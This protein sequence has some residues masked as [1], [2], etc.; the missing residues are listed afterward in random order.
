MNSMVSSLAKTWNGKDFDFSKANG[1][2]SGLNGLEQTVKNNAKVMKSSTGI[3]DDFFNYFKDKKI[4]VS[5]ELKNAMGGDAYKELLQNNIGKIV[6]DATKGM[7]IDSIWGEMTTLF[8]EHF[9]S[10]ITNQADQITKA[11]D[12]MKQARADM[13]QTFSV[14]DLSGADYIAATDSIAQEILSA[15]TTMKETLQSNI[16]SATEAGKATLDL[17][18]EINTDKIT[19]DIR[20][21]IQ[22]AGNEAGEAINVDLKINNETLL[23]ELRSAIGQLGTGE[24][25]VKV[26]LQVDKESLQSDLN[27]A[28]TDMELPVHFN[29][30]SEEIESQLRSAI[31]SITD[32]QIDLRINTNE[33]QDS[34]DQT[35]HGA[36]E[37][38]EPEINI[39]QADTANINEA[40]QAI[41]RVNAAGQRGQGI[42]QSLGSSFREAFTST[43]NLANMAQD[44][45]FRLA[46]AGRSAVST[47]KEFND[48][49]T[50]LSMA[51]GESRSYTKELM[52]D[53]N[54]M[55]QSLGAITSDVAE[56]ADSWLRQ[57][58]SMSETN[59]L[60]KDSMVLSK[61][62]QMDSTQASEVLTATLNGFQMNADQA[63]RIND[64][65]T[66]IDL[67][68][69]SD[70][71]GIGQALTKVASQANNARVSL[72]KTAAMIATIKD[73]TQASDDSIGN[74]MKSILARMNN[75]KA[76]K[77]VD[78]NGEALNDVEKVLNK[79]GISMRDN[80][81]QFLDSEKI[82]DNVADKWG[83]F[84]KKTQKAVSTALGGTYQAN[85][86]TALLDN[87]D[88]VQKLTDVALNS[89]G[90]AQKKFEDNYLS[91]LE[92]KTNS[93]KASMEDLATTTLSSDLYGGF[94]DGSKAVVD[95]A[96]NINIVKSA[97]AGLTVF[98]AARGVQQL[99]NTF[100]ELSNFGTALNL[101]RM[102]D[103]PEDSFAN[104]LTMTQGLSEA[105]TR[106]VLSNTALSEAQRIAILTNQGMSEA[107]AQ[108]SV[109]AMGLSAAEGTAAASTTTLSGALSGLW[110]TLSANPLLLISLGVTAAVS[111]FNAY[112]NSVK[113]AV[114]NAKQAGTEWTDN[115][116]SMND[117]IA[118]VTELREAL[119]SGTLSEQ[120][121]ASAKSELLSI[122]ESLTESYGNQVS[123]IDLIN[124][125]LK[126]QIAL[127]DQVSAKEAQSYQ[128]ENK[129][130]IEKATK[131]ME[132][133]RKAYLGSF[134][135]NGSEESEAIKDSIKKLQQEYGDDT[136]QME[137]D[138]ISVNVR[139]E[140]DVT[141]Q[142]EVL[143]GYMTE[144]DNVE[145]KYKTGTA[146]LM[147][148]YAS[149]SLNKA[150]DILNKY[151]EIYDAAQ[152][153][154]IAS[155]ETLYKDSTGKEQSAAGW[156]RDY[157]KAT[158][159]YNNALS[160]GDTSKIAEA[161]TAFDEVNGSVS[162]L[163]LNSDMGMKFGDNF[164]EVKNQLDQATISANNF[165]KALSDSSNDKLQGFINDLKDLNLSD[166]DF[167]YALETDGIQAGEAAI[168]GLAAEAEKAGVST[169]QL[170]SWLAD[171][172]V[173]SSTTGNSV[174]DTT[175]SVSG[176]A[177]QIV[178]A[179]EAL[180]G[181]QKATSILTSQSTGKSISLDDFNS[182]ELADYTSALE[183]SNGALQLNTEKVRELQKA[184]AEEAIQTNENQKL[185]K[186]SQYMENI[187]Q[188]EQLQ[189]ELRGLSDAKSEN[190]QAIQNSID[191][192]L[193]ENDGIVNQCNQLDLLSASLREA[194]GA[195]QNW[196]DKQNGSESGDMFDDAMG[197]LTHIEDVT[198]NTESDDYGRIGTNS[199]K[200]AV[201]F[202]VPDTVDTQDAEAVSS[203]IDSI[204]HYFNHDSDGNRTGLDV[205]EFCAKATK[206]GL[207]ELDEASGEY[208]VAG[209][210]TMQDFADGLNLSL[211]MV[212]SMF[213]E[214]EE[215]GA[216]FDWSDEAVKT[217]G[218]LGMAAG[219]AKNRIEELS[220][221]KDLDIQIDVSDIDTTEGK[222]QTLDN[223]IQQMQDYKGT[224]EVDSSQVDDANTI[225]Q[226]CVTQ[227]QM[228]ETPAVMNVD[229]SQVDGELG[230]ALSLLQQFQ[231]AQNN[232]E[233]QTAVG[234]DTSEAQG[235]VDSLVSEIQGLSPEIQA[236][237]N[238]DTT[239]E[240]TLTSSIKALSPEIMVK[241]GVDSSVV[242]AY[243]SEEKKSSGKVTWTNDTGSVDAWAS[244]MHTSNG[245]VIWT[246]ETS[247]VRTTFT[248]TGTVNWTNTTAP[249]KGAG[250]ASGTA[251]AG[252]TAHYNH[253]VGH[254]YANGNWGTKT[255]GTTLV[256]ELGR[257][258]V[259]DPGSGT[260]HT[261]GD[262]GAEFVN[263]P[264]GSIVFNHLQSEALLERGFVNGRGTARANGTAMVRGGISVNQA[265]IASGHTTY[266][267]SSNS[268]SS[269]SSATQQHT[270]AVQKDTS[271]TEDNTKS[272]KDS[273]E[274]FDWV[275]TKLDKFA[276]S[277]ER[278]SNQIT[279]YIS[280]TFKTVLLKRQV[281]AVE[282]QLKAN[283]QGYTAYMNKANSVDI[284]DDYK[285]KVI[286]GTF[287]IEEIDT[288]S[289]SG[290][291]LAKDIKSFQTY[292]NSAQDCKDTVQEL[293]NKLLELYETI[294]NM[295]T[296]KA[297]K[298]IERLKTK[299]E[300]LNAVSDTVSLG[301]SA[302]AAMQNQI[303]VD[304]PGLGNAQKKLDKAETAR[305]ITKK[306][307]AKASK[308]LKSATADAE[309]TGNTLIKTSE[310]QTKSIGKKLK[311]AA[312][313][314]TNKATYNAIAQAVREGKAVNT[315][316]LK[317][318]ALK[319]AKS[320]NSSL[321][322]GNTIASKVK[323]GKTVKTSGMSN[324]LKSTAQAYNADAKE[325]ASAQKVYD[326]AKKADEKALDNLTKAQKNKDK[327]YAGST[328][329]QQILATTKGKK[330]YVYQNMLLTQETKNLKEQNKQRQKA[331]KETRDSYMK[332][333]S[334]YDTADTDKT[335]S[336]N[337]LLNNKTVMS[338]LNK[339][340]QKALKAGKTV[341]TKG[342]TDSKVLKWIQDYN[343]KV[344][345]ST[346]LSKKLRI[347][348]EALDKATSEAAQSQAEYA[349]SIVENAKK[350]LENIANYYDSFTSQWENRNSMYEAYMDRMQTQG[351]NLSTKFYEA[352]IGQQQKIV[353]N[354]SQKYIAMKRNFANLVADPNSG[355][356]E[357]T[358]EYYEMQNEIDQVAI[359][360]KEAQ[361]KVVEFQASIR[362]LKWEQF[363]QLQEA[364]GRITSESDFLIDLMSHKDMYDKDGNMTEQGLATMGLHGVNYNTYMA[365]ADKY[366]EEMLKIS[367]E[368]AN[369]PNNQKLIDR[370]NELIDAQQQAI[371]SAEDEKDSIKDL[372]QDGIDK[373][374]DALD[375][376]ID[377]YLDCLDSEK[378]LYEYRKKIG[379][380]S[381]KI[382]SLQKQLSSL[383]GDNSE[384]NKAKL[385]KLKEDLK[386][387][388][389]DMEETQYDKYV[390]DQKKLL[391]EL[392][393]DYKKALDD[394][395]DNVDVL[396]SD[397]IASINSNSSNISQTLQTESKNVGYTLSGEM[398]TIWTSQSQALSL[399]DG[400]FDT[401]FTGVTTA[402]G[403]V[404]DRQKDMID[405]IDTMAEKLVAKADQMLQQPTKTE[406]VLEEV[407][408]KPD[409]DNV[410]EGNPTPDPPKVSDDESI[411][412][413]VLVDPDEPKKKPNKN[414]NKK[415]G[416]GKAEVG[417][418]V[419]YVSGRYYG[420][421]DGGH[422]SG[423]YYLGKK[424]KIT[425]I[426]KGSKYPY[427][428]D[429]T[430]GTELGWVKLNQLKGY[431][432]GIMRVPNDQLAWTQEQGEEAIVRNDGSIL[433]PL[434]RDVSV[435]NADMTKN[436]WDFM[437]N[438]GSFLSNYSDGEKFGVK[439]VDNSSSVDVGGVTIQ[440]NMPNVQNANDL[441]H[442]LTTNK[443]IEKAIKAMTI[444]RI[445]G[446]SSLAKYKYRV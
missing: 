150:N 25:P 212:Q 407:E 112:N 304:N 19:S 218:D 314:S 244:Q 406:G 404:Y 444:D 201:D 36:T 55:G 367:E 191:A 35:I 167:E 430:D 395:M 272:A 195:Y 246:N 44:G 317:G 254:A 124:G 95:F 137:S 354:L 163:M 432:S 183:Y 443:D 425:R 347:E 250:G 340:Q 283:E 393:Q 439:N 319:Y 302:I 4:Y 185:E 324:V 12:V 242:D 1:F 186:Q 99:V 376:L 118:K 335:K 437:G 380:Q 214:M 42:F 208:K 298:K 148:D 344:K 153:A 373:Q 20:S 157:A 145:S 309:S 48:L 330:S 133:T 179:Q 339:T 224:L 187:A 142:K 291:Q 231:S 196:L 210:R 362:D 83:N 357:G 120:E 194:T 230:N 234:A 261:V 2:F 277:V 159:D 249:T 3:Y 102:V 270:N 69:A 169:D 172:N 399:Y 200:A 274:A 284:S 125:S 209:Q 11:F 160:S 98:G 204:E 237:L 361:N 123:G 400:K 341:S 397:A 211:P 38:Q 401:R 421:S 352:E 131:E 247:Q 396:I 84:D 384:E 345:K 34:I 110:A 202:I 364:I 285:N 21:A 94:L 310:K 276:K 377:K 349:Q 23:S 156:L 96:N 265:N 54:D 281:K 121:A 417:D 119:A 426:N 27:L 100:R 379:E 203:Y 266:K 216:K 117:T 139:F 111:A 442:E 365:Q 389:D 292:Y 64:I 91:S 315:K 22:S 116:S 289:D 316:G 332:A 278:I 147:S 80:N 264:A 356:K 109:A 416:N 433:T 427:A 58:R 368:L 106:A 108:A 358:E 257:E 262:N 165:E 258:I 300:S 87:Y 90:T 299:L 385:Q 297:E 305:N 81:D 348:Q 363:D 88:K 52:Q 321:K 47:V 323:A 78:D 74:A 360:L 189:D 238:I 388:Q 440:C 410:A 174:D 327:L 436:L 318:A 31:E 164:S 405:A 229:T 138:G 15:A 37:Q 307:R 411:R 171:L 24:E 336:Q 387:A 73:V 331:L 13:A 193:S 306:T 295:P 205:A 71:G 418:K 180:T 176:L 273:T 76:G 206:A 126:E 128:N 56:S 322:Q 8:P 256:G 70:A 190:A 280:S 338:K 173:I 312:K 267:G 85:S 107:E 403:N 65:L 355:I 9:S 198:Q 334:K 423:N 79:I 294:V 43:Y 392:K 227:K 371:L 181:I 320:Y 325:K 28:L 333:K 253:L 223:T 26:N 263:I 419:T 134:Y 350:K 429:A 40:E 428:I 275:K 381:E 170:I 220:G 424:V 372:I 412:D 14:N 141:S 72:E 378:D 154:K 132:K 268:G 115:Y 63:S 143:N 51:T 233:L 236:K 182:E 382:A 245:Q 215:F 130:G 16:M 152:Q 359:S 259:V 61:D 146:A 82:I 114:S 391:D 414:D 53:Y 49:E 422:G 235:K 402:I 228:L 129:R 57:G 217:L 435:L 184:K 18:V 10:D 343:E 136:L 17:D 431:A 241:A 5:D 155:D 168:N 240:A 408:Q 32:M 434:S 50:D 438:P 328:K 374:L 353:D 303:K 60:I 144:M 282:K 197:A 97:L 219:E 192:L 162:D 29:I 445:R 6:R 232:V 290:K 75:I 62:A 158:D 127:L 370:K 59:Q 260:W 86:I 177:D 409:K 296:E 394:R 151:Q 293:N 398:Q 113:E 308:T 33:L 351:Y 287:S 101:S 226:Y 66:S 413:A 252:G 175:E 7:S 45:L 178:N 386:S 243:A 67:E 39:P 248:A 166:T 77:F 329:E 301:G 383:Q 103:I 366:K 288:S 239:S 188:I 122:Q 326:N 161:K 105:Q 369:D 441:L 149:D 30:D 222:I 251:H 207:M 337:K 346:D 135:D 140:G 46:E 213:G 199:Y 390:S 279:D 221:D 92:A 313:S 415:T 286:N 446:G 225:I 269:D 255:G 68:S 420:D 375:D 271:A 89:E 342:I 104:L 311:S 93:L 41:G